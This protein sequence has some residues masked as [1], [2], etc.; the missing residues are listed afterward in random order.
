MVFWARTSTAETRVE[1]RPTQK[2]KTSARD[3][4]ALAVDDGPCASY[5]SG[6]P[7]L[8]VSWVRK[9]KAIRKTVAKA[10]GAVLNPECGMEYVKATESGA[11]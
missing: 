9:G 10:D 2:S 11:H 5:Q 3:A 1:A 6:K 8:D 4:V 7:G